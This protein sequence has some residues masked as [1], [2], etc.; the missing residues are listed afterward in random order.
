MS[1]AKK[2][3][4]EENTNSNEFNKISFIIRQSILGTVDTCFI[5]LVQT[6]NTDKTVDV[7]PLVNGVDGNGNAIERTVVFNLPYLKYQGGECSV[8]I[9][10]VVGDIGLVCITKDDSSSALENK[11]PSIPPSE[12]KYNKSNGFYIAS[13]ASTCK[14]AKHSLTIR[15]EGITIST[16]GNINVSCTE[17]SIS[18]SKVTIDSSDVNLGGAG[19]KKVALD[20]DTVVSGSTVIGTVKATSTTTKAL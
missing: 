4:L 11:Q 13:I 6:V 5:G 14:T 8:D 19:G 16:T 12:K 3:Y 10:P 20:G 7:L 18:A 2:G 1:E 9:I 17:A 15:D